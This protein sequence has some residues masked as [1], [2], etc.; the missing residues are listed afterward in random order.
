MLS[1][2]QNLEA[3]L[4]QSPGRVEFASAAV[5]IL[6]DFVSYLSEECLSKTDISNAMHQ[7][8]DEVMDQAPTSMLPVIAAA[9]KK[10]EAA[11]F[12]EVVVS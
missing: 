4:S 3:W 12:R 1:N 6:G 8:L 5:G 2:A 10:Q 9:E 7:L 11:Q